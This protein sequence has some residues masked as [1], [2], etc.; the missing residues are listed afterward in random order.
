MEVTYIKPAKP[1]GMKAYG[2]I[3]HLP[4]S[5]LG[6][7]DHH[8]HEGQAKIATEKTRDRHDVVIIQEKLDGSN[9][10]VANINGEIVALGRSGYLAE[11]SPY[12]QHILF[13]NWVKENKDRFRDCLKVGERVA[14]EWLAQAHGTIYNLTHEPYV[15]FDVFTADNKRM[16]YDT[17]VS[18]VKD[19]VTPNIVAYAQ[20]LPVERALELL[21]NGKHGAD[22]AEGLVYR[23]ER[24]GVVDFLTKF[25]KHSKIDGKYLPEQNNGEIIWNWKP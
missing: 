23:I 18:K 12:E 17:M 22:E 1:L 16:P 15:I 3:P 11:S 6:I 8:C 25:V 7:G 21:G 9:C 2:S 19:F 20:P 24:R 13:A 4:G 14:G 10:T 5:R